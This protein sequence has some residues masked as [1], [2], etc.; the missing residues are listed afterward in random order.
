M[1]VF[2]DGG[3]SRVGDYL[4]VPLGLIL[5]VGWDLISGCQ[6]ITDMWPLCAAWASPEHGICQS[7]VSPRE[8]LP[9][10]PPPGLRSHRVTPTALDSSKEPQKFQGRGPEATSQWKVHQRV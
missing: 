5:A 2:R 4:P 6:L 3:G 7:Q 10:F 9:A 1:H 8:K